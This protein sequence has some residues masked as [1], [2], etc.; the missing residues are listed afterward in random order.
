M[1]EDPN[2]EH[3]D[4]EK[5]TLCLLCAVKLWELGSEGF[6]FEM[7]DVIVSVSLRPLDDEK[8]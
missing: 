4:P 2:E 5:H 7:R 1:V 8:D 6:E 3:F